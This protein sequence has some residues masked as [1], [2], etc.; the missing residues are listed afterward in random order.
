MSKPVVKRLE[1]RS[2]SG[3]V[4]ALAC[5]LSTTAIAAN[6]LPEMV[7][8][9]SASCG[10]IPAETCVEIAWPHVDLDGDQ[11]LSIAELED[12]RRQMTGLALTQPQSLPTRIRNG[13]FLGLI[14][15]R[16]VGT[17]KLFA[18]YDSNGD[19]GIDRP[20]LLQDLVLDGRPLPKLLSDPTAFDR[21]AFAER[22][23]VASTLLGPALEE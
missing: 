3:M 19:G 13:V 4:I 16:A 15:V 7:N 18:S 22:L 1:R 23:G 6:D 10:T 8:R 17:E 21:R 9:L 5:W 11:K 20:E 14:V 12:L 2:I